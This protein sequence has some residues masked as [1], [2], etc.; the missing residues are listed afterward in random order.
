MLK[1]IV[2]AAAL[3]LSFLGSVR[4]SGSGDEGSFSMSKPSNACRD[5]FE[6][7]GGG[8]LP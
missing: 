7:T 5:P 2:F 4:I 6:C 8:W 1:K 3:A